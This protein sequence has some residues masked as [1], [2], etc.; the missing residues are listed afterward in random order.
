MGIGFREL[1]I[2]LLIVLFAFGTKRLPGIMSDLAKGIRSFKD[3]MRDDPAKP[4]VD[5]KSNTPPQG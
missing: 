3:G 2:I 4:P 1:V 5:D